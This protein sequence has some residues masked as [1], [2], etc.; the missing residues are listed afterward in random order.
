MLK[1][2][3]TT[4]YALIALQHMQR[5]G[6]SPASA[7]EIAESYGLP[8]EITAKTLLKLK[9]AGFVQ[10]SCGSRGGYL[11]HR[12]LSEVSL[13]E[14]L[15]LMEGPADLVLCASKEGWNWKQDA[16]EYSGRCGIRST[17]ARLNQKVHRFLKQIVLSD[18][19]D[20][21][22]GSVLL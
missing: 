10:S 4:E 11:L 6:V 8:F 20:S 17:M 14:F 3:R 13:G 9:D 16:C 1:F 5:K 2:H 15:E 18:L 7:R 19:I 21:E 22:K 12:V